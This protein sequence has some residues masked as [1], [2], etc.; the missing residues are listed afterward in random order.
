MQLFSLQNTPRLLVT[1]LTALVQ[2]ALLM[3]LHLAMDGQYWPATSGK[4]L[5][6]IFAAALF[7]PLTLQ[8][9]SEYWRSAL[10][11]WTAGL[12][13][14]LFFYFG[15]HF[16]GTANTE[17][18]A[19]ASWQGGF[20][21]V[22]TLGVLWLHCLPF[23]RARLATGRWRTGYEHLF[24]AAWQQAIMLAEAALFTGLFWALL[25][26]WAKLF[27][28]LGYEFFDWLFTEPAFAY[29]FTTVAFGVA[30]YL[31]GSLEKLVTVVREQLLG[32]LKWPAPVAGLILI[33]FAPTLLIKLP[34]LL[35]HGER[36]IGAAWLLW[37][38]AFTVLLLNAG[39]QNGRIEQ[40]YPRFIALFLR[41]VLPATVI[42]AVTALYALLV[43]IDEYGITVERVFAVIVALAATAYA[44]GYSIAAVRR[45][46]WLRG[47]ER[48]NIGVA[49]GIIVVLGLTL[50]PVA[51][52]HRLS[53][54][55][56]YAR[57]LQAQGE[58][59]Q[60]SLAYLRFESGAY[61][62]SALQRLAALEGDDED[63]D[64]LRHKAARMLE[65]EHRWSPYGDT[66]PEEVFAEIE[67]HP[68]GHA[69][70]AA[71]QEKLRAD[72]KAGRL[73]HGTL[74]HSL[75]PIAIFID[76]NADS[77]D[78]CVV[79]TFPYYLVYEETQRGWTQVGSSYMAVP[80]GPEQVRAALEA[81]DYAA[82]PAQWQEL[83][84]GKARLRAQ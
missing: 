28:M 21:F 18:L 59:L 67:I 49:L 41:I 69:M 57:A 30:L 39:Y 83:R 74:W 58:E 8:L 5:F 77:T 20:V 4:W 75:D 68:H 14:A 10:L 7:V 6:G 73:G 46:P 22:F 11:W 78:E 3:W 76:L 24:A 43:R 79:I 38:L 51:S 81:G 54:S 53:A 48:I 70:E 52:P 37:L 84:I 56:Q 31:T 17:E 62:R 44:I 66:A 64:I 60:S 61:G 27:D 19:P 71:L 2:G 72:Y 42:V 26:L 65:R 80:T 9:A 25:M 63:T 32:L 82:E 29:P 50:T 34:E 13:T 55:S 1:I 35:F 45:G 23:L 47:I 16:G 36:A 12:M 33:L 15:W 40:P